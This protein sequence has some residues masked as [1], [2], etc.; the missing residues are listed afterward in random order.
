MFPSP[1]EFQLLSLKEKELGVKG[2]K[3]Y[4]F[5]EGISEG[6]AY[7]G[8]TVFSL[9]SPLNSMQWTIPTFPT[10]AVLTAGLARTLTGRCMAVLLPQ[11]L[12][13]C[14]SQT[15]SQP[16][17]P[18]YLVFQSRAST[19]HHPHLSFWAEMKRCMFFSYQFQGLFVSEYNTNI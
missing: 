14:Y 4:A 2:I 16:T 5:S 13:V 10:G 9:L 6:V 11:G 3:K 8:Q 7:C 15:W 19:P 12:A 1:L 18:S 17:F